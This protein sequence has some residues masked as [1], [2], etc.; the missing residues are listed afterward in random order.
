MEVLCQGL[1]GVCVY[2]DDILITGKTEAEHLKNLSAVLE[3]LKHVG[4]KLNSS[5]SAF[6][7]GEKFNIW[8]TRLPHEHNSNL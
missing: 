8:V 7:L 6:M 5:K 1:A 2:L 4:M 3:H